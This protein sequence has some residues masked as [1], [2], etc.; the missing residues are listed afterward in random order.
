MSLSCI[1]SRPRHAG[2]RQSSRPSTSAPER[3]QLCTPCHAADPSRPPSSPST[4]QPSISSDPKYEYK[5]PL[6]QFFSNWLPRP[7]DVSAEL[8]HIDWQASKARGLTLEQ[9]A[10]RLEVGRQRGWRGGA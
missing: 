2:Q 4:A 6:N 8:S 10:Q 1:N 3:A 7:R 5:D 9:M